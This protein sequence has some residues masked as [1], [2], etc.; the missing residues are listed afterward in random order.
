MLWDHGDRSSEGIIGFESLICKEY[1][2]DDESLNSYCYTFDVEQRLSNFIL[3]GNGDAARELIDELFERNLPDLYFS[4]P[5]RRQ[6][7]LYGL[8]STAVKVLKDA[9]AVFGECPSEKLLLFDE[10]I[11]CKEVDGVRKIMLSLASIIRK[12]NDDSNKGSSKLSEDLKIFIENHY[13][14]CDLSVFSVSEHFNLT[15][16]YLSKRF[17]Q[18][19]GESVLRYIHKIRIQKATNL[20]Y[21][22]DISMSN[23]VSKVGYNDRNTF[24]RVFKNFLGITPGQYRKMHSRLPF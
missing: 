16:T 4:A 6:L 12:H 1:K 2:A 22:T 7:L 20:L 11:M 9:D 19:T 5:I 3:S 15:P 23:I 18:Q 10:L 13:N 24:I 14:Q 8:I 21:E 17:K